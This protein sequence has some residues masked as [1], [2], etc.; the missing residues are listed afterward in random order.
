MFDYLGRF[1]GLGNDN[2]T[3][4]QVLKYFVTCKHRVN[5][6]GL[7]TPENI[8]N[9]HALKQPLLSCSGLGQQ[10]VRITRVT[11]FRHPC[12]RSECEWCLVYFSSLFYCFLVYLTCVIHSCVPSYFIVFFYISPT[13]YPFWYS[14]QKRIIIT[15]SSTRWVTGKSTRGG[16][17]RLCV[18]YKV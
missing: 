17:D 6:S 7:D 13:S 9:Q 10:C 4:S 3:I 8:E 2:S 1:F 16:G 12:S 11:L 5:I 14:S 15:L 18:V